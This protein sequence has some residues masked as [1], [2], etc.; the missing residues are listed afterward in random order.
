M[1]IKPIFILLLFSLFLVSCTSEPIDPLEINLREHAN[2]AMHIHP[3]VEIEILG[4]PYII[5]ADT[6]VTADGMRV[7]H[8]HDTT[9]KLHVESPEPIDFYLKDFFTI[10]EKKFTDECIFDY[11]VDNQHFLKVYVNGKEDIRKGNIILKDADKIKIVYD[12]N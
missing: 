6:G 10:W 5:P 3:T 4:E 9:G 1:I 7:I 11:C 12:T 2:L 8:T